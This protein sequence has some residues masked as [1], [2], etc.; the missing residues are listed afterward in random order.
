MTEMVRTMRVSDD[1]D[2]PEMVLRLTHIPLGVSQGFPERRVAERDAGPHEDR[3]RFQALRAAAGGAEAGAEAPD[4]GD[5]PGVP[6]SAP[7][8]GAPQAAG[9]VLDRGVAGPSERCAGT[10]AVGHC[11]GA[12]TSHP[13]LAVYFSHQEWENLR[14]NKL[15]SARGSRAGRGSTNASHSRHSHKSG[16]A[17]CD[18]PF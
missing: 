9:A 15:V 10:R 17:T 5:P 8:N 2:G 14:A 7:R 12:L 16:T 11:G 3:L 4:R 1:E 6:A 13:A 18:R